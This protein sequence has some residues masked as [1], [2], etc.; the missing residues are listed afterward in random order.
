MPLIHATKFVKPK[1]NIIV[2]LPILIKNTQIIIIAMKTMRKLRIAGLF[3]L[4]IAGFTVQNQVK[5]Q[6]GANVSFQTF[7]N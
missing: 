3:L 6:P 2:Q 5:A 7:Y 4:L 1:N